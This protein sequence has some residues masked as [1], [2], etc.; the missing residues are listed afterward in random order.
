[1]SKHGD[2][3]F[4]TPWYSLTYFGFLQI[5]PLVLSLKAPK[6]GSVKHRALINDNNTHTHLY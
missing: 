2:F 1:M 3:P 5:T 4:A 6:L